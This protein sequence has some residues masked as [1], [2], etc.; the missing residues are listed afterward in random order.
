[1]VRARTTSPTQTSYFRAVINLQS[2]YNAHSFKRVFLYAH[3]SLSEK[4][5]LHLSTK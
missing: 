5:N 3:S 2:F 4:I 1:M